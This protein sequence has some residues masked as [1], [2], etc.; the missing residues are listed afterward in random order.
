[1][2]TLVV[3]PTLVRATMPPASIVVPTRD[4]APYLA[5]ALDSLVPQARAAGAD[6][7][8]VLDGIDAASAAVARERGARTVSH[9]HARGLNAARN[10]GIAETRGD[11]VVFVDDDVEV[12]PGWLEA[13]LGAAADLTGVDVFTGPVFARIEDHA[14]RTCGR[15]GLPLTFLDLGPDD[16]DAPHAWGANLAIRRA[17]FDRVGLFD[18]SRELYGDEQEWQDRLRASERPRI[19]YVAAAALDHRR[20]GDDARLGELARASYRRGQASRR[21]DVFKGAPPSLARELVTF[22]GTLAHG[23]RF[24]C[25]NGPVLAAHQAGR[26]HASL[27]TAP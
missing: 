8:V 4:R 5:V 26:L 19:R 10:T 17:A 21:Y 7:L 24:A 25:M 3:G 6:V 9:A 12:R 11:L 27:R 18:A 1:M 20:A 2:G 14:F 13:L 15:E 23:P 22:A 16:I